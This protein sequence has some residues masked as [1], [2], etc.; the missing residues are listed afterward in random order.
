MMRQ[1]PIFYRHPVTGDDC[2]IV[3]NGASRHERDRRAV[4][5]A[6]TWEV[7]GLVHG[8]A[9]LF[10]YNFDGTLCAGSVIAINAADAEQQLT[11]LSRSMSGLL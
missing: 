2:M 10:T 1:Y 8:D 5:I 9:M 6:R 3:V 11:H 4:A 7:L